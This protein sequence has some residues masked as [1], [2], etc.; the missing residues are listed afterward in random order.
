MHG[1]ALHSHE[2][3]RNCFKDCVNRLCYW[4]RERHCRRDVT[5]QPYV[6]VTKEGLHVLARWS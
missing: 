6:D 5:L 3:I 2:K 4:F 1:T